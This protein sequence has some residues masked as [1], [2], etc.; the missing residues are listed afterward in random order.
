MDKK[1]DKKD[2]YAF[3]FLNDVEHPVVRLNAVGKESCSTNSYYWENDDRPDCYLFQYT[4]RGS[5]TV[6]LDG[7]ERV[8]GRETGFFLKMPG[9]ECYYFDDKKNEAPWEFIYLLFESGG[10]EEY[11]RYIEEHLG[12]V[13]TVPTGSRAAELL[14][15]LYAQ[16][17]RPN[18]NPFLLGSMVFAFLCAL[19]DSGREGRKSEPLLVVNAKACMEELFTDPAGISDVAERCSVSLSHLSREFYKATGMR[20][21]EYMTKL[22]LKRAVDLLSGTSM[23]LVEISAACG[24]SSTNYFQKVFR[25]Y[26]N[27]SPAQFRKYVKREGYLK[28]QI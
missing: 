13:I 8:V 11:C 19:C 27:M 15:D 1:E 26:M 21:S 5:G 3:H 23:R 20:P 25:K 16:A 7:E 4:L 17:K 2:N 6:K 14:A 9:P 22:R 18:E 24:F 12:R 28:F 10:A